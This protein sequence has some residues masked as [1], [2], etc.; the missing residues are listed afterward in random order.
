MEEERVTTSIKSGK[1]WGRSVREQRATAAPK[2]VTLKGSLVFNNRFTICLCFKTNFRNHWYA[3]SP[4][5]WEEMP[6]WGTLVVKRNEDLT[7][8]TILAR[9][10]LVHPHSFCRE[11]SFLSE[12]IAFIFWGWSTTVFRPSWTLLLFISNLEQ[13]RVEDKSEFLR[14]K[15]AGWSKGRFCLLFICLSVAYVCFEQFS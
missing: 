12:S 8:P 5:L 10:T 14:T 4:T 3:S 7:T 13:L 1:A 9:P 2:W 11:C 15:E 6:T